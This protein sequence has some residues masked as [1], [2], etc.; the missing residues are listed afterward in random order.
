[1]KRT[2]SAILLF[3]LLLTAPVSLCSCSL[4]D[5]IPKDLITRKVVEPEEKSPYLTVEP[6][7]MTFTEGYTPIASNYSYNALPLDDERKLYK[8][9]LDVCYDISPEKDDDYDIYPMPQ[10]SVDASL[11]EAQVRTVIKAVYDDNPELFWISG[12]I[13]YYSDQE[14]TIVQMYSRYAPDEID[15]RLNSLHKAASE[16]FAS[17]PD[18]LSEYE[19]EL[20]THDYLIECTEYDKDVDT[21]DTS[22][23]SPDIYTVYGALVNKVAVCEGYSR[24]FQ[25]LLNGLGVDCVGVSGTAEDELHMWN[26]VG[27]NGEWYAVDVTWD[28]NDSSYYKY[29]YFN[30][31]TEQISEDHET[32]P[33]FSELS[34][35]EITGDSDINCDVMNTFVPECSDGTMGWYYRSSPR[36]TD[37]DGERIESALMTAALDRDEVFIF[38]IDENLDF[39][40][41]VDL[42]FNEY[43]QYFFDYVGNVNNNLSDC[44]IDNSNLGYYPIKMNRIVAV[45][46]KYY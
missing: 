23:N 16:F 11:S 35:D 43:P 46:L 12:S 36:L 38:Y 44:S 2:V 27:M 45:E 39:D 42:L 34:D 28:D 32:S 21:E 26:A 14:E 15:T 40:E 37:Y 1:M 20:L 4:L 29:G 25:L 5:L 41:A 6:D 19:R 31:T 10:V 18:G 33:L 13:G 17:V 22:K 7:E 8:K 9:L 24:A 30:L 3:A